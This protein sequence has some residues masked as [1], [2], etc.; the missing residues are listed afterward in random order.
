M[1]TSSELAIR[2]SLSARQTCEGVVGT[3][4]FS[5]ILSKLTGHQNI[6]DCPVPKLLELSKPSPFGR[7]EQTLIDVAIRNGREISCAEGDRDIVYDSLNSHIA[8][9]LFSVQN[10]RLKFY[11]LAIYE[12]GGKQ[13]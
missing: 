9:N 4:I 6:F 12:A 3:S 2:L 5:F 10:V 8:E 13:K 7:G 1:N 11:K